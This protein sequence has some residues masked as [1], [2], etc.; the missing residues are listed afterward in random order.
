[1]LFFHVVADYNLQ[2]WLA[3]A[4]QKSWWEK[5]EEC[6]HCMWKY[7]HDYI[8]ALIMH[9]ISWTFMVMLPIA[10]VNN[11]TVDWLF[12]L[13]FTINVV[14]HAVIDHAKANVKKINLVEDQIL[15]LIQISF[16]S[17]LLFV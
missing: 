1:M 2:G 11:F 6:R 5:Q 12:V 3:T 8:M 4:K 7:K 10:Y 14:A 15:H 16:T 13:I 9:S 17:W